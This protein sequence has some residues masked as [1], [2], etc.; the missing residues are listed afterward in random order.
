MPYPDDANSNNSYTLEYKFTSGSSWTTSVSNAAHAASPYTTTITGLTQGTSYDVR[1]TYNDTDG[2]TGTNPQT[3]T[4][5][6]G[7]PGIIEL[8]AWSNLYHGTATTAQNLTYAVPAGSGAR[9]V[10]LVAIASEQTGV[11]ARTVTLTYGGQTLTPVSGDM[12]TTT[13]RQHTALYY[14]NNGGLILAAANASPTILAATVGGGA[15]RMTD[16]F[17]AVYDGVDQTTAITDFKT[18][19]NGTTV[20]STFAFGT[21][22]VV[23]AG[24]QAVGIT[25]SDRITNTTLWTVSTYVSNGTPATEKTSTTT[26]AIRNMVTK[27]LIPV[28]NVA[29]DTSSTLMNGTALGS[30][31]ALS[32][33][34]AKATP[35]V[36]VFNSLVTYNGSVQSATV[37]GSVAGT[38]SNVKYD[39]AATLP[40]SVGTYA[41]TADFVANDTVNYGSLAAASA[42]NFV[43]QK[44]V[45]S[46]S[47]GNLAQTQDGTAKPATATTVP[48]GLTLTLTY[49]GAGT[50]PSAAGSYTVLA[51]INEAN[52]S[53][54]A[55]GTLVITGAAIT[56]WR[57]AHFTAAEIAAGL[58][59][60][61]ADPDGDGVTNLAEFAFNGDP[62]NGASSGLFF[63]RVADASLLFTCAVRR[64]AVFAPT[65]GN[66][67]VSLAIDGLVYAI[68]GSRTLS[69]N[70]DGLITDQGTADTAPIGSGLPDLTGSGWH[71]HTFSA[72]SGLT[73]KGFLRAKIAGSP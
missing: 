66:A 50:P 38:V 46:I 34:N 35:T 63:T 71:Y 9:R 55:S 3:L 24:N 56:S 13:V 42:G 19:S 22:L 26:D 21:G 44:A 51:N 6:T 67:Q 52:Y 1:V 17:A 73:D 41:I 2:V 59:A 29:A 10:L 23:N 65:A 14:L 15:T 18:Y 49:N 8:S 25:C 61:A 11:A 45:A 16:V 40:T 32:L 68:E 33:A 53:G 43:I 70:W 54:S 58:A 30:M 27:R 7:S 12:A 20:G 37:N 60:D 69:G 72:F 4:V 39:G 62:R 48:A 36:M 5:V 47:L 64:G 57:A 31:T 28:A